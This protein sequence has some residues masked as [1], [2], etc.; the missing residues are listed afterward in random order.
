MYITYFFNPLKNALANEHPSFFI[1]TYIC[2][3]I[4]ICLHGH[5]IFNFEDA[6]CIHIKTHMYLILPLISIV[7]FIDHFFFTICI[8]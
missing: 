1:Y 4:N 7:N 2:R 6:A 8:C 3:H 5:F